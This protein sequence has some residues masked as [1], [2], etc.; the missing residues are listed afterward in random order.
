M[1]PLMVEPVVV[2]EFC[3]NSTFHCPVPIAK[4]LTRAAVEE[5]KAADE[6]EIYRLFAS[7]IPALVDLA[8]RLAIVEVAPKGFWKAQICELVAVKDRVSR[9]SLNPL[10]EE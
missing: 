8:E 6:V 1:A 5:P 3:W 4:A 2:A 9:Y 7:A 10:I